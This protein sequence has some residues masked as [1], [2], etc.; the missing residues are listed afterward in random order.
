MDIHQQQ[1]RRDDGHDDKANLHE[2]EEEAEQENHRHHHQQ[3]ADMPARQVAEKAIDQ[4][5]TA[6]ATKGEAEDGRAD[7]DDEHHR[8]HLHRRDADGP[9]NAAPAEAVKREREPGDRYGQQDEGEQ[10]GRACLAARHASKISKTGEQEEQEERRHGDGQQ[11]AKPALFAQ[12]GEHQRAR[13]PDSGGL[14]RCCDARQ[15]GAEHG[16]D[17]RDRRQQRPQQA[18]RHRLVSLSHA[19][20]ADGRRAFGMPPGNVNLIQDIE[21]DQQQPRQQRACEKIPDG[22]GIGRPVALL[23]LRADMGVGNLLGKDDQHD[24]RRND[25]AEG[26]GGADRPARQ[27]RII[28]GFQHHRQRHEPHGDHRRADHPGRGGEQCANKKDGNAE[29]AMQTPEQAAHGLQQFLRHAGFFQHQPHENEQRHGDHGLIPHGSAEDA[30]RHGA[31]QG[32]IEDAEQPTDARHEQPGAGQGEGNG[33]SAQQAQ[34]R[35][36]KQGNRQ[37]VG[38]GHGRPPAISRSSAFSALAMPCRIIRTG[39][40]SS[41][42]FSRNRNGRPVLSREPS[43][44]V[45]DPAT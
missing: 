36:K 37:H 34:D 10:R 32:G 16:D 4:L 45:Q 8:R 2:I 3:G 24:G 29:P 39:K 35:D 22:D 38:E 15:D 1:H 33:K 12:G 7:Q 9:Q 20:A 11:R 30:R 42:D 17:Q 41:S 26:A 40:T 19:L 6:E 31:E 44:M 27:P 18:G 28:A 23:R 43:Q 25:L 13:S 21:P 5:I 14:P